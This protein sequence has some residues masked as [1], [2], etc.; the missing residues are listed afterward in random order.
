MLDVLFCE[1]F[2]CQFDRTLVVSGD[3][4]FVL[5]EDAVDVTR[6]SFDSK[7]GR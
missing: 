1:A 3:D 7:G 2:R 6:G 5:R 4:V